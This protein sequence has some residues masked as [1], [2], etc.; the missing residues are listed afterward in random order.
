MI[1]TGSNVQIPKTVR[2]QK[3][4]RRDKIEAEL[5]AYADAQIA[6]WDKLKLFHEDKE[7]DYVAKQDWVDGV[8]LCVVKYR[9]AG[10]TQEHIDSWY[11]NPLQLKALNQKAVYTNLESDEGHLQCHIVIQAPMIVSNRCFIS[12]W[13]NITNE[14]GSRIIMNSSKGNEGLY[15]AHKDKTGKAV[16]ADLVIQYTKITPIEGGMELVAVS[17]MDPNGM[18]PGFVKN[19]MAKRLGLNLYFVV[20]YLINGTIPPPA[21]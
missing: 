13:Y 7:K 6:K 4:T 1:D 10:M 19:K 11:N 2:P 16:I 9:A 14:D 8:P 18:L 5:L 12:T 20:D 15:D 21:F 17:Q 3:Q